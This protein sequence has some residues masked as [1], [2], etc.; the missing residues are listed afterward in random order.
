MHIA[1]L[2]EQQSIKLWVAGSTPAMQ[3]KL[4]ASALSFKVSRGVEKLL[5]RCA[6]NAETTG[7]IPVSATKFGITNV[8][9][10]CLIGYNFA[11]TLSL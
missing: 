10:T 5:S 7:W 2:A 1:H 11:A 6:H 9:L 8:V 3:T 4:A